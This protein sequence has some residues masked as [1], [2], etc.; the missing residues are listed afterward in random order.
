MIDRLYNMVIDFHTHFYP[1]KIV[2][3][4]LATAREKANLEPALDGTQAGLLGSMRRSNVDYSVALPL[5][6]Q[7]GKGPGVI[8]WAKSFALR[9]RADAT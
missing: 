4:A 3:R 2:E 1:E 5:V 7:I 8:A 9:V 6:T